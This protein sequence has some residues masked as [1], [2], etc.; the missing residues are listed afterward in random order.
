MKSYRYFDLVMAAF[1]AV[2][3]VSNIASSAK[4]VDWGVSL[5]GLR[6]SFDG[7]T[8]LFPLSY[9]FGDILTEVYGF[10]RARRVIWVGFAAT[11]AMSAVFWILSA[12]PGEAQWQQYAGDAAYISILGGVSS[13]GIIIAS[14]VAYFFGAFSNSVILA[15]MKVRMEGRH[16]WMR[17]IGSTLVGQGIDTAAFIAIATF[18]GVFPWSLFWNLVIA[19]YVFKVAIEVLFTPLTYRL[20]SLL[21]RKEKEDYYDKTTTFTPFSFPASVDSRS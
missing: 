11:A 16:L 3:L 12:L 19:N 13:G 15:K 4:I 20:V 6:L 10:K 14:L 21:K 5:Y 2:L 8:L 17:T 9:I 1:V 18:F 7:G